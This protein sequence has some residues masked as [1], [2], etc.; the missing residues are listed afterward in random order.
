MQKLSLVEKAILEKVRFH[1]KWWVHL[2]HSREGT[3]FVTAQST[4]MDDTVG[5]LALAAAVQMDA[6][7]KAAKKIIATLSAVAKNP[8]VVKNAQGGAGSVGLKPI[9]LFLAR[10]IG[11]RDYQLDAGQ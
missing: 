8:G 4:L 3:K 11:S 2:F 7:F 6:G 5:A 10:W 9:Y 1:R